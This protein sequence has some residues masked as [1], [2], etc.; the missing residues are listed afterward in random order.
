MRPPATEL[1]SLGIS[2][3]SREAPAPPAQP[4]P[5]G[6]TDSHPVGLGVRRP[7]MTLHWV[8]TDLKIVF[9]SSGLPRRSGMATFSADLMA[10]VKAADPRVTCLVAAIDEPNEGRRYGGEVRWRIRQGDALLQ[11]PGFDCAQ[12]FVADRVAARARCQR[13]SLDRLDRRGKDGIAEHALDPA[14][15][16]MTPCVMQNNLRVEVAEL[17]VKLR[18]VS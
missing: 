2:H 5:L 13:L 12:Q 11:V 15:E 16:V 18:P 6:L 14:R 1:R 17:M 9:V 7:D 8:A 4:R 3:A 10:A